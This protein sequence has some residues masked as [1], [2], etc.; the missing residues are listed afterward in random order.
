MLGQPSAG[1]TAA[2]GEVQARITGGNVMQL[3]RSEFAKE[4]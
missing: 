1:T 2:K 4:R 3:N